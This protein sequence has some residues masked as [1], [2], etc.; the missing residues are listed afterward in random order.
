MELSNFFAEGILGDDFVSPV[1]SSQSVNRL[2]PTGVGRE[3]WR[4]N[5]RN[6]P[7]GKRCEQSSSIDN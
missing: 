2:E 4:R 3:G 7:A 6:P 1:Q 5:G